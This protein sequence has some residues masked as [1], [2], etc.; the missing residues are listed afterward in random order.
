[1]NK[2]RLVKRGFTW[3]NWV[4]DPEILIFSYVQRIQGVTKYK[5]G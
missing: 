4:D 5:K 3:K 2:N 1:M